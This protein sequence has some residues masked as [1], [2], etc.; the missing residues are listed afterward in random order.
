M[1]LL[2]VEDSGESRRCSKCGELLGGKDSTE[3]D[4]RQLCWKC[5][6]EEID[7]D[8]ITEAEKPVPEAKGKSRAWKIALSG[9]ILLSIS[10]VMVQLPGL[11]TALRD[12]TPIRAGTYS[13]DRLADQCIRN[14]W[15]ISSLLQK[16]N[17]AFDDYF[18]PAS[19]KPYVI[20]TTAED[21][22]VSCPE[23]ERHNLTGLSIS[24]K[25]P[26]PKVENETQ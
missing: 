13:T 10:I 23:P 4:D 5:V 14:L 16:G 2:M 1:G 22:V 8:F 24:K 15:H 17:T 7:N 21:T 3:D 12:D 18:C 25:S 19:K 26:V 9:L 20:I 11:I 6:V